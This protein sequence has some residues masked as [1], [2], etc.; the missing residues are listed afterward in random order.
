MLNHAFQIADSASSTNKTK[1]VYGGLLRIRV[2]YQHFFEV[3][4]E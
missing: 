1:M 2:F 4:A 3:N